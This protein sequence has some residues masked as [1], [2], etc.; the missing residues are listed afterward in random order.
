MGEWRYNR[1]GGWVGLRAGQDAVTRIK[2]PSACQESNPGRPA[3]ILVT[4]IDK[5]IEIHR[6]S[7]DYRRRSIK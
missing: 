4:V 1:I 7:M 3:C 2:I 6:A 5:I